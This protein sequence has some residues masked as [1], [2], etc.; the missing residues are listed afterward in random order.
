M[1]A[2]AAKMPRATQ[3]AL[4][5][6]GFP[7]GN[8][9]SEPPQPPVQLRSRTPI[10]TPHWLDKH[11]SSATSIAIHLPHGFINY[12]RLYFIYCQQHLL[13]WRCTCQY[14]CRLCGGWALRGVNVKCTTQ[15][16]FDTREL[17]MSPARYSNVYL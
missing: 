16:V 9:V 3:N 6:N 1:P 8:A 17:T 7:L 2:K 4:A 11:R 10:S 14:T 13:L 5:Q 15:C 12:Q